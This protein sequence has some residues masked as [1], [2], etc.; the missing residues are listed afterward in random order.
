M[1]GDSGDSGDSSGVAQRTSRTKTNGSINSEFRTKLSHH[2][3]LHCFYTVSMRIF[4]M[5]LKL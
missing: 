2:S 4:I 3:K 1:R 5:L